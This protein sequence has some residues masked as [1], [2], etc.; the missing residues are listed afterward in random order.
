MQVAIS[1]TF[2]VLTTNKHLILQGTCKGH[3]KECFLSQVL[4]T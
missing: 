2:N 1:V 3:Y 4:T